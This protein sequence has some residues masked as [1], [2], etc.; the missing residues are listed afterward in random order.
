[1]NLETV[2]AAL[3]CEV[4]RR[5]PQFKTVLPETKNERKW[6]V[7]N[8]KINRIVGIGREPCALGLG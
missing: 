1:M 7:Q 8:E 6:K 4:H 2:I 3:R 5:L